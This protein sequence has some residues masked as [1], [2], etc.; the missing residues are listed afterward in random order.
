MFCHLCCFF[1]GVCCCGSFRAVCMHEMI[2]SYVMANDSKTIKAGGKW[3]GITNFVLPL[4]SGG[5]EKGG[6]DTADEREGDHGSFNRSE[7]P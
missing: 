3:K 6:R 5:N 1:V 4:A 2:L 7:R